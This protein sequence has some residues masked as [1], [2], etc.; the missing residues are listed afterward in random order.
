MQKNQ[1]KVTKGVAALRDIKQ[2][3]TEAILKFGKLISLDIDIEH[4]RHL[5]LQN[6]GI[7]TLPLRLNTVLREVRKLDLSLN[8]ITDMSPLSVLPYLSNLN[9]SR[10]PELHTLNR[11]N[12]KKLV[13]LSVAHCGLQSLS[14]LE[15]SSTTLCTLIAND[16]NLQLQSPS[17]LEVKDP[18]DSPENSKDSSVV[19]T[20]VENYKIIASL[21]ALETVVLSRNPQL[22]SLYSNDCEETDGPTKGSSKADA[23]H[24]VG[25]SNESDDKNVPNAKEEERGPGAYPSRLS[26][27]PLAVFEGLTRLVKLSLSEC[28]IPS[29]PERWFLPLVTELRLAHNALTSLQPE[30][31]I[32]RSVKIL[33]ISYNRLESIATL[34]R[35]L[36]LRQ[37][38]L[39]GN[40]LIN[41]Y[42]QRD[43]EERIDDAEQTPTKA[44]NV[45]EE[46]GKDK[47]VP[48]SLQRS[49]LRMLKHLQLIDGQ[50]IPPI[51]ELIIKRPH[52]VKEVLK[53][54]KDENDSNGK[55]AE[56]MTVESIASA[57]KKSRK[58]GT[59]K[60]NESN[61]EKIQKELDEK[62][63]V[64]NIPEIKE[65]HKPIVR[66]EKVHQVHKAGLIESGGAAVAALLRHSNEP[67]S[68]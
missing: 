16:N 23:T 57:K 30:G 13:V 37:I 58:E 45:A 3:E 61:V 53:I 22:C 7:H 11:L 39:K 8:H 66:R 12:C 54:S 6:K 15:E 60:Q 28:N 47:I 5:N 62:D 68:W 46:Q 29:L 40:P 2:A 1:S 19:A 35:C 32:L 41:I 33:D 59:R 50:P 42:V 67:A 36:F 55:G 43:Q 52:S 56:D 34:R 26:S 25:K 49:L 14:G 27:H 51:G 10:N 38:N 24:Q 65:T 17:I 18:R 31:V 64:L 9:L 4:T 44:L 48:R 20:A 63:V 21:K